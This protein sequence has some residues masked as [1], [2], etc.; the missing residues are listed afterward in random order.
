MPELILLGEAISSGARSCVTIPTLRVKLNL[1]DGLW[2][3]KDDYFSFWGRIQGYWVQQEQIIQEINAYFVREKVPFQIGPA[4]INAGFVRENIGGT[5]NFWVKIE[6]SKK[7]T[8]CMWG[9][10]KSGEKGTHW[11]GDTDPKAL[12][13][14]REA[15][16]IEKREMHEKVALELP[17]VWEELIPAGTH[18]YLTRKG[19]RLHGARLS[20]FS[21]TQVI[22]QIVVPMRLGPMGKLENLHYIDETGAKAL[23]PGAQTNAVHFWIGGHKPEKIIVCEGYATGASIY[24]ALDE[25]KDLAVLCA[26]SGGNLMSVVQYVLKAFPKVALTV[27]ADNDHEK[28]ENAGILYA[29]KAV[30]L[31]PHIKLVSPATEPGVSDFNDVLLLKGKEAVAPYFED[32]ELEITSGSIAPREKKPNEN[33]VATLLANEMKAHCVSGDDV[34]QYLGT[35]WYMWQEEDFVN[36]NN[37]IRKVSGNIYKTGDVASCKKALL[38][39]LPRAPHNLLHAKRTSANF[40]NGTLHLLETAHGPEFELREHNPEDGMLNVLPFKFDDSLFTARSEEWEKYLEYMFEKDS[41]K[42]EKILALSEMFGAMLMPRYPHLF[43]LHGGAACGKSTTILTALKLTRPEDV[44]GVDPTHLGREFYLESLIG[45]TLNVL[46][47]INVRDPISDDIVKQIEDQRP[48]SI[49]RKG[50]K[51][52]RAPLPPVHIFAGNGIPKTLEGASGAHERRWTFIEFTRRVAD[53]GSYERDFSDNLFTSCPEGIVGFALRGLHSLLKRKGVYTQPESGKK[54][55]VEWQKESD[56]VA[57]FLE[58]IELDEVPHIHKDSADAI[59]STIMWKAFRNWCED[60][61]SGG[62]RM[63]QRGFGLKMK[64]LGVTPT[65]TRTGVMWEGYTSKAPELRNF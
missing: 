1:V 32:S 30:S 58:A 22:S 53:N 2:N 34:F 16:E 29:T 25:P 24:E 50:Q 9:D 39:R 15:W 64:R 31:A 63:S 6:Q 49:N 18:P 5:G 47:D 27:A 19:V 36:L 33:T 43:M 4:H 52:V 7:S 41:D 11:V 23:H 44:G 40:L 56:S 60:T 37:I 65:R 61:N 59:A 20:C 8:L 48:F 42:D 17:R 57:Q 46:T 54:A 55:L 62:Q 35:H 28:K 13:K 10:F 26:M 45:K 51:M 21:G 14:A 38:D 12:K 3:A